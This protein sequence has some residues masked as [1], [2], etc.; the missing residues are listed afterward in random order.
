MAANPPV[1]SE[2]PGASIFVPVRLLSGQ[3]KTITVY[4]SWYHVESNISIGRAE[5]T[6]HAFREKPATG[7]AF[8]Q[9]I[10]RGF[11]GNQLVNVFDPAGDGQTGI[12]ESPPFEINKRFLTFFVGGGD[13]KEKTAV[14]LIIGD[15]TIITATG[16][17]T[18]TLELEIWNLHP[19]MGKEAKIRIIDL[20]MQ[21]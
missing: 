14:Q 11:I 10:V 16:R 21:P 6:G 15:E 12:L 2:S 1:E 7:T 4:F 8:N 13:D 3:E 19:Y 20:S 9:Q 17:R 5:W 18:E